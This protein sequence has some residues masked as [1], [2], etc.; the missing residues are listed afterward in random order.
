VIEYL[1]ESLEKT[2]YLDRSLPKLQQ[3]PP[4]TKEVLLK[5]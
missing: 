1:D 4:K 3:A 2:E 5:K